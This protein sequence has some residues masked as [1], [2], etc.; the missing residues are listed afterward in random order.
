MY[1][2]LHCVKLAFISKKYI[3]RMIIQHIQFVET[4]KLFNTFSA[5]FNSENKCI[6]LLLYL[7]DTPAFEK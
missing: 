4:D 6:N 3:V 2:Y 5:Y 7:Y 1:G